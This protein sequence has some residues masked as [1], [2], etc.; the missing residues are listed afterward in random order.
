M[1][2]LDR[3][4][5]RCGNCGTTTEHTVLVSTNAF[6]SADLDLRPPEMK[7]STMDTWLQLCPHCGYCGPD[8]SKPPP[9]ATLLRSEAYRAAFRSADYPQLARRFLAFAVA[10]GLTD[11]VVAAQAYLHA[12][13]VCDDAGRAGQAAESRRRAAESFRRCQPFGGDEQGIT[14]GAVLVD[15]LRRCGLFTQ[16]SAECAALLEAPSATGIVRKV[17]EY[18]QQLIALK[19]IAGHRISA[20]EKQP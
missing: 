9:D 19:D 14:L 15:V 7:R 16:A 10:A 18:Q 5:V 12:A 13:W 11:P 3:E 6:G 17:L 8:I 1:T 2:M 4:S 20:C